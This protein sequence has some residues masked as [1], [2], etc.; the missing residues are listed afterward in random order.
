MDGDI[1]ADELSAGALRVWLT[2]HDPITREER[3]TQR[4]SADA[5]LSLGATLNHP[6]S[7]SIAAL[8]NPD[9]AAGSSRCRTSCVTG[10]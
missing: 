10:S 1:T 6:K 3:G 7:V 8:L 4:L 2:G 5:D 9:L